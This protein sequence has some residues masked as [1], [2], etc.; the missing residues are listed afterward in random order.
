MKRNID[1]SK[2]SGKSRKEILSD[3]SAGHV[4]LVEE[5]GLAV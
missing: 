3:H 4:V 2:R 5:A 1:W